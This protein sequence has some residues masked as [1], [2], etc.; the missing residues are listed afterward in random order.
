MRRVTAVL[1]TLGLP[2][3]WARWFADH[4]ISRQQQTPSEE[5]SSLP[6]CHPPGVDMGCPQTGSHRSSEGARQI[7]IPMV[8]A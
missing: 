7:T 5:E 3:N 4:D 1:S 6:N 2:A 8:L